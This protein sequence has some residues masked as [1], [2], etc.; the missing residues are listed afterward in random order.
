MNGIDDGCRF[1]PDSV[2]AETIKESDDY[3]GVR[4]T[5]AGYLGKIRIPIQ[6]DIGFGD[7]VTPAPYLPNELSLHARDAPANSSCLP[8]TSIAEKFEA[9]VNS[10]SPTAA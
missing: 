10:A 2:R 7:A 6:A 1:D 4:I 3:E 8:V 9:M 5:L